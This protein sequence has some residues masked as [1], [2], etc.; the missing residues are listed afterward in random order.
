MSS[1]KLAKVRP[2]MNL[3]REN[4]QAQYRPGQYLTADEDMCK[5]KGRNTMKQYM[6]AK[7][8]KWG[9]RI[10]KLCDTADAYVLNFDVYT[11]AKDGKKD[12]TSV[13]MELMEGYLDKNHVVVMDNFFTSVP[14][15]TD[16]LNRSTYACGT[17]RS[18]R[19]YLPEEF[20]K[21]QK[22]DSG[23]SKFWQSDN[24]V[25]T[26]WQDKRPVRFLSTCCEAEGNDTV[27]RKRKRQER[28]I[29]NCPPAAK[30]YTL[31]MGGVDRSDRMVRTYS[32]SRASKKWWF[33]LFYYFLDMAVAN[34][35]ILY[36]LSPNHEELTELEYIKSLSL[37]LIQTFSK[38][39]E[40]QPGP[41]RKSKAPIVPPRLT[42]ANHWPLK[43]KKRKK[44]QQCSRRGSTG[45]RTKWMCEGCNVHLCIETCFKKYHTRH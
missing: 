19:K 31:K 12:T 38:G 30:L 23:Q 34:S 6:K 41:E 43:T 26:L 17:I 45:G 10:W 4:F 16:L 40:V 32:V 42:T 22:L 44:C 18:N 29:L 1:D 3:L 27:E 33:R 25:A 2:L 13:V 7:I 39:D 11:G 20:K 9:Y 15:F 36:K 35:F 21:E 14:L 8:I 5:F 37:A 24:F 28:V